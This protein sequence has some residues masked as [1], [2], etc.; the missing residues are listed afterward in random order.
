MIAAAAI[1][2]IVF[3]VLTF[4]GGV[5][6]FVK[7][8]SRASLIAGG[9]AGAF[10]VGSGWLARGGD[11]NGLRVG[12]ALSVALAVRFGR[13]YAQSRKTMPAVPMIVLSIVGI[14]L[15]AAALFG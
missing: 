1:Y 12:L 4:A 5:M 9:I 10:L 7:A 8:K 15:T 11:V 6:G 2:L 3:G 13:A 14:A